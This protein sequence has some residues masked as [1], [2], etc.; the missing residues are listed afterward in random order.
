MRT[1][2]LWLQLKHLHSDALTAHASNAQYNT[3]QE[4]SNRKN[5][6][7]IHAMLLINNSQQQQVNYY[8]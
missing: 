2:I 1:N 4:F 3:A 8:L 6:L 5:V 7:F